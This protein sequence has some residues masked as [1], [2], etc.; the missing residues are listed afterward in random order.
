[1]DR[2]NHCIRKFDLL[3][4]QLVTHAGNCGTAGFK[5]G[6]F[7]I[8]LFNKPDGI[9]IDDDGNLFVLD[10]GNNYMRLID[11]QG[12][13]HTL[14]QGACFEYK[15]YEKANNRVMTLLCLK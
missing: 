13:V 7:G 10:T 12:Y 9:G 8:N 11:P 2:D 3:N 1:V 6:H 14:I 4:R 5:D 15:L